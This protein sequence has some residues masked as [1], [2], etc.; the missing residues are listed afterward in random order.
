MISAYFP[1]QEGLTGTARCRRYDG[2][3][4]DYSGAGDRGHG[5]RSLRNVI[6]ALIVLLIRPQPASWRRRRWAVK[7]MD[8]VLAARAIGAS[9]WRI[10]FRHM[11]R[12]RLAPYIVFATS[13]LG[14]AVVVEAALSFLGVGTPPDVLSWV[15]CC[16]LPD[17]STSKCPPGSWLFPV[18]S[19][20]HGSL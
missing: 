15:A 8:C 6:L 4:S 7:E 17:K 20:L 3:P 18:H 16:P 2:L 5:R 10:I 13:N 14:H 12:N 19:R 11:M 1:G 9:A